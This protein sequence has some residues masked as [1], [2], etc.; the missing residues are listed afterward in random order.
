LTGPLISFKLH[1]DL[2]LLRSV[3]SYTT[4]HLGQDD[5]VYA[6]HRHVPL[7]LLDRPPSSPSRFDLKTRIYR[8]QSQYQLR[9]PSEPILSRP[10]SPISLFEVVHRPPSQ[11]TSRLYRQTTDLTSTFKSSSLREIKN[12]QQQQSNEQKLIRP[13]TV[14]TVPT[15]Y[16][17]KRGGKIY[18]VVVGYVSPFTSPLQR[19]ELHLKTDGEV[20]LIL[21]K[22]KQ[23]Q[24]QQRASKPQVWVGLS[25]QS[26]LK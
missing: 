7:K 6:E 10:K 26:T 19:T 22:L 17:V 14:P 9:S 2:L 18:K 4:F 24:D 12:Q 11:N 1:S 23:Q 25:P 21:R 20:D 3:I 15:T 8:S 16:E 13:Q 5:T